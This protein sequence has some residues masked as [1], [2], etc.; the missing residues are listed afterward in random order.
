MI[1]H[2]GRAFGEEAVALRVG[3]GAETEQQFAGVVKS[4]M[5]LLTS[6]MF[7][8]S[9]VMS[10]T[11]EESQIEKG[12]AAT[13]TAAGLTTHQVTLNIVHIG[14][15]STAPGQWLLNAIS[16]ARSKETLY[17]KARQEKAGAVLAQNERRALVETFCLNARDGGRLESHTRHPAGVHPMQGPHPRHKFPLQ[18][19]A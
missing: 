16:D 2:V 3:V 7:G 1:E 8:T 13:K 15:A 17:Q 10:V 9:G 5:I 6:R 11:A 18:S 4:R 19:P 14:D 12:A